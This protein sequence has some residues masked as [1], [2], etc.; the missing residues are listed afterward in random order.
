MFYPYIAE[1]VNEVSKPKRPTQGPLY[2]I[3][4]LLLV[5]QGLRALHLAGD[6]SCNICFCFSIKEASSF[7]TQGVSKNVL[8]GLGLGKCVFGFNW[9]PILLYLS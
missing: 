3:H 8:Q 2:I 4:V 9:C 7:L 1:L 6:K 5:M